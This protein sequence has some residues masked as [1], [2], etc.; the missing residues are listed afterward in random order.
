MPKKKD[1]LPP[2][3]LKDMQIGGKTQ[4]P[5][6]N[7]GLLAATAGAVKATPALTAYL[8]Y[9]EAPLDCPSILVGTVR[10]ALAFKV[11]SVY[12]SFIKRFCSELIFWDL[13]P[14]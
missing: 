9:A 7:L 10:V 3:V 4:S 12:I 6:G 11:K 13:R 1:T 14:S 8:K 2:S 5:L